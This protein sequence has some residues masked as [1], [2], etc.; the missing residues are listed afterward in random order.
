[1]FALP[2]GNLLRLQV[3]DDAGAPITTAVA[4]VS[5]D[6]L[7]FPRFAWVGKTTARGEISWSSA[8]YQEEYQVSARGY[9]G[10]RKLKLVADGTDQRVV[11][12]RE[13]TQEQA[14]TRVFVKVVD[15]VSKLP[16]ESFKVV[17]DHTR[18]GIPGSFAGTYS[19]GAATGRE[20]E[21]KFKTDGSVVSVAV[22][23]DA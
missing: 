19:A 18:M 7:N 22:A 12:K 9:E 4:E 5:P 14:E 6:Q 20:G 10:P 21:Y 16:I 15:A 13:S 1:S 2:P 8:P 17:V 11:L 23:V 3:V